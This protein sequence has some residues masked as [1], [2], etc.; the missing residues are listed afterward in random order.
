MEEPSTERS[1]VQ[2][3]HLL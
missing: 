3:T 2:F 1:A